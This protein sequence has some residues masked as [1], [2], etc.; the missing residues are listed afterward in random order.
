MKSPVD[1]ILRP[2]EP[3]AVPYWRIV[4]RGCSQLCFQS[5]EWTGLCFLAAVLVASPIAA[6]YF[7]VAAIVAPQVRKGL[8]EKASVLETGMPGLNPCMIALS[9][10]AFFET[11]W[12]N[13]GMWMVLLACV[14]IT[15]LLVRLFIS[16]LPVPTLVLPF[17]IVF[18]TL[19]ACAPRFEVLQPIA[20]VS[21][22]PT[23]FLP[24][25][26]VLDSLGQVFFAPSVWSGLLFATGM[27]LSNWRH[28]LIA[29]FG[30][31]I[32]TAVAYYYGNMDPVDT[33]LG[34]Y[35]FNGVLTAV[36]VYLFCGGK[37]RLSILGALLATILTPFI[38]Q[39]GVQTL[40]APLVLTTWL[41][42]GLGWFEDHWF[43]LPSAP[44]SSA[45]A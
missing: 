7:L 12:T 17:L 31:T 32:G 10:P 14:L 13:L 36:S 21:P 2:A 24:L 44:T 30:A 19:H 27:L 9:L 33:N 26:A 8:G 15:V 28:G 20:F 37:L 16:I 43:A 4:L 35:G 34:L 23:V 11:G 22:Q 42:I 6:A 18:W 25:T 40:S 1:T 5:N 3:G 45:A 38:A 41:M 39:F 29:I